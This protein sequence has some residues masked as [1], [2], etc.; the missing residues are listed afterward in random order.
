MNSP[1]VEP[2]TDDA[3]YHR[4]MAECEGLCMLDPELDTDQA[5]RLM[6]VAIAL[7]AYEKQR[8]PFP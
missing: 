6:A 1:H 4:L 5:A 8:W 3:S 7:E 2:I